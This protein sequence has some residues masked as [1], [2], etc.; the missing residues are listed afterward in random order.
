MSHDSAP[1]TAPPSA[2]EEASTGHAG[3]LIACGLLLL[4]A[5]IRIPAFAYTGDRLNPFFFASEAIVVL[6][7]IYA[8]EQVIALLHGRSGLHRLDFLNRFQLCF[9]TFLPMTIACMTL[10]IVSD[11]IADHAGWEDFNGHNIFLRGVDGIAFDQKTDAGRVFSTT[12]AGLLIVFVIERAQR[13]ALSLRRAA[14]IFVRHSVYLAAGVAVAS[15]FLFWLAGVQQ[16]VRTDVMATV[17]SLD[18]LLAK[19]AT[20]ALFA[21]GFACL[22]LVAV[23]T[24]FTLV[25]RAS[26]RRLATSA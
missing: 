10:A 21:G 7:V 9:Q 3:L 11:L 16:A 26:Y 20:I 18:S 2:A 23:V 6:A 5:I 17:H 19:N 15:L 24:I 14:R 25:L 12:L 22:R 13:S 8:S 4:A 1:Q